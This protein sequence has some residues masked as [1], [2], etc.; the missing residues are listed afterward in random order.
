MEWS[1][2]KKLLMEFYLQ[3]GYADEIAAQAAVAVE[4]LE[5]WAIS[6]GSDL[7]GLKTEDLQEYIEKLIDD[8]DNDAETLLAMARYMYLIDRKDLYLHFT[9]VLGGLNVMENIRARSE[10]IIGKDAADRVF[11]STDPPPLGSLPVCYPESTRD[12]VN[13]LDR[14]TDEPAFRRILAGNN[15]SMNPAAFEKEKKHFEEAASLDD[16]LL[17]YHAR[18]VATLQHHCDTNTVWFEQRI[19]RE[20]CSLRDEFLHGIMIDPRQTAVN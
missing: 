1:M 3:R 16:F 4:H 11:A 5:T 10:E 17:G 8:G 7:A 9:A 18:K 14:A 20:N 15:H 2:D 13:A 12:F 19:S 6:Q